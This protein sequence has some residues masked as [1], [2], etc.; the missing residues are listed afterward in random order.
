M[1][2]EDLSNY[3]HWLVRTRNLL[4]PSLDPLTASAIWHVLYDRLSLARLLYPGLL[5]LFKATDVVAD[6]VE[7][8]TLQATVLSEYF[9]WYLRHFVIKVV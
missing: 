5:A 7:S 9:R 2:V 3:V 4:L 8:L 6:T 1:V